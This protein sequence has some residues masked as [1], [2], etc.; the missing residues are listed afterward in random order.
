MNTE[1]IMQDVIDME[2][3]N[4]TIIAIVHRYGYIDRFDRV[5]LLES[6]EV[7]ECDKPGS[8]LARD[9][10]FRKFYLAR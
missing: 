10:R 2:F 8:L 9:S 7:I 4:C 1:R 6:G 3:A 5:V